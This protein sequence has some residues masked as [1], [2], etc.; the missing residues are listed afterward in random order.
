MLIVAFMILSINN[1]LAAS[2]F[3]LL[4]DQDNVSTYLDQESV[5]YDGTIIYSWLKLNMNNKSYVFKYLFNTRTK[6]MKAVRQ[7]IYD[8][9]NN[10]LKEKQINQEWKNIDEDNMLIY[11]KMREWIAKT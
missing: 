8:S 9:N 3:V 2:N 7:R 6:Q 1:A 4:Y 11:D 10:L 5:K